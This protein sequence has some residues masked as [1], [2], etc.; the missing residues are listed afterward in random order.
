MIKW[1]AARERLAAISAPAVACNIISTNTNKYQQLTIRIVAT[2]SSV[3]E[4]KM[5]TAELFAA[6]RYVCQ[7]IRFI[8]LFI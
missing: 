4:D 8:Y 7:L 3:D 6:G 2:A 5:D 1:I